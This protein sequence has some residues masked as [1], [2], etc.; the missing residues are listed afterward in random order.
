MRK[1]AKTFMP[2]L[3]LLA[4][5]WTVEIVN[6]FTGHQLTSWGILPRSFS[7]ITGIPLSPF[8]H[9]N[10]WHAISNTIP[11]LI[12]GGL[13]LLSGRR[14]FWA[15]TIAIILLSGILVWLFA[16]GSYHVG[17]SGLVFGYF[18]ALLTRAVVERSLSSIL[19]AVVTIFLYGGIIWGILPLRSY[20]SFEG[21]FFGLVA[22]LSFTW[23]NLKRARQVHE[24]SL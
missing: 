18:G 13:T 9:A 16:R 12:L 7:G 19:I 6:L 11:L 21:H 5:I 3:T 2:I 15:T 10:L 1:L 22:G 23:F 4:I 24:G 8:I 20:I 17:A 14:H